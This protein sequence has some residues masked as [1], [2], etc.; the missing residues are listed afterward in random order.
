MFLA[1]LGKDVVY[2]LERSHTITESLPMFEL[3]IVAYY[4]ERQ[5]DTYS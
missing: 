1:I 2:K 3:A 4:A 5:I